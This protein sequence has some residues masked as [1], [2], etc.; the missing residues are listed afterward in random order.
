MNIPN[1]Y[2]EPAH[3]PVDSEEL[4]Y[5]RN[6]VFVE[7]QNIPPEIEFDELDRQCHHVLA[8]DLEGRPIGTG[9]LSPDG[10]IGRLAVL[11]GWRKQGVGGS[12]LRAIIDKARS[13]GLT[14]VH[15]NAQVTALAFYRKFAFA[16]EGDE[17]IEA[18]IP[19]LTMRL[20]LRPVDKPPR[21]ALKLRSPSVPA[22]R[23][24]SIEATLQ[25]T[26]QLIAESRRQLCIYSRDLE[27]SLY[28]QSEVVEALK[29]FALRSRG[30]SVQIIIQDPAK[31]RGRS[32]PLLDLA[33]KLASFFLIRTPLEEE[34]L[35]Y[36]S[37]FV[38]NDR[39][40]YL[41]RLA[42]NR[43]EGHWSPNLPARNRQLREEFE[44]VWQRSRPC[45]EFRALGW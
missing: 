18:G 42:G 31:L 27:Y 39:D 15:A 41:F 24:A 7:E 28:G 19:H 36:P 13:L 44:R 40:G 10:K 38:I 20:K 35:Q 25:S 34:D 9:R 23:L 29:Q 12:L 3:Y 17:F 6:A 8:R 45:S 21:P 43:F 30:E 22:A 5:V 32:H 4:R 1:F 2:V 37:A 33:Q 14:T 26:V 11:P 16:Q